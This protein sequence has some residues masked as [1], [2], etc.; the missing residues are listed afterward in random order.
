MLQ[1]LI[2]LCVLG[3]AWTCSRS[4]SVFPTI[5]HSLS[6]SPQL[7]ANKIEFGPFLIHSAL[8]FLFYLEIQVPHH[9]RADSV[10]QP[11]MP[12]WD[13]SM[14]NGTILATPRGC[15]AWCRF[16]RPIQFF[17]CWEICMWNVCLFFPLPIYTLR[18][19]MFRI[20]LNSL[21]VQLCNVFA[22]NYFLY[23]HLLSSL[24]VYLC[25]FVAV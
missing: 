9:I 23:A 11:P 7:E 25:G 16:W 17:P 5:V 6:M 14:S 21:N 13:I 19:C 10:C 24:Y 18:L 8:F 20:D 2:S 12:G 1:N 15:W 22:F 3:G 4:T